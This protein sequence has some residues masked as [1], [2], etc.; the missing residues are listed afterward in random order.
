MKYLGRLDLQYYKFNRPQ[1]IANKLSDRVI[2]PV[3]SPMRGHR[4]WGY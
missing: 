2:C 1:T 3:M 4:Q